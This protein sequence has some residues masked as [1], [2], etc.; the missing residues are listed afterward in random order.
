MRIGIAHSPVLYQHEA[1][2]VQQIR[3]TTAALQA[4][5]AAVVLAGSNAKL[6]RLDLLHVY[7]L[8]GGNAPLL[9]AAAA[10]AL[11]VVFSPLMA[12]MQPQRGETGRA[13]SA[14]GTP[15]D[16]RRAMAQASLVLALGPQEQQAIARSF[17][18]E[19]QRLGV[20]PSGVGAG[21][22]H[23]SG[24]LFRLRTG[25]RTRFVLIDAPLATVQA[26]LALASALA[27]RGMRLLWLTSTP[28]EAARAVCTVPIVPG[29]GYLSPLQHDPAMLAS[30]LAA[31]SVLLIPGCDDR[32]ARTVLAALASGTPVVTSPAAAAGLG[33][34]PAVLR[35][36]GTRDHAAWRSAV[37]DLLTLAAPRPAAQALA[38]PCSW[39]HAA[40]ALIAHY[41]RVLARARARP[42]VQAE[43][44]LAAA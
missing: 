31:A 27:Q 18:V 19:R 41:A 25:M 24:D 38:R 36:V 15:D 9:A 32:C 2:L 37:L 7:S 22:F 40:Q 6:A 12:P 8:G 42:A 43:G 21:M 34:D 10:R 33:A 26:Q 13:A 35:R 28:S 5:H 1:A 39:E 17:L 4:A 30:A 29:I 23:V 11:P 44:R 3:A 14:H 20:L 16:L